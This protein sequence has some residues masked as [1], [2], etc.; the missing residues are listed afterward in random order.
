M[1]YFCLL[2]RVGDV[3]N[4][5]KSPGLRDWGVQEWLAEDF[6]LYPNPETFNYDHKTVFQNGGGKI[7]F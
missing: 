5:L 7:M 4:C 6:F 2:P 3:F 1:H